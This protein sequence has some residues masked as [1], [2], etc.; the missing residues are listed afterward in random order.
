MVKS[1]L[2]IDVGSLVDFL[3]EGSFEAIS[4]WDMDKFNCEM[5]GKDLR[6]IE[7]EKVSSESRGSIE[8]VEEDL[9]YSIRGTKRNLDVSRNSHTR[10]QAFS[11]Q[12]QQPEDIC[13]L[14]YKE[15][16]ECAI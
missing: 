11:L 1:W 15:M 9:E 5:K 2:V 3:D 4:R 12:P 14:V 13:I 16:I 10:E 7:E 8:E 6:K